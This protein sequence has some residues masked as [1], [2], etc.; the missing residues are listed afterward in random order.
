L[1]A[2]GGWK[3]AFAVTGVKEKAEG[4]ALNKDLTNIY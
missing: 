1:P 2:A 4:Q 3:D